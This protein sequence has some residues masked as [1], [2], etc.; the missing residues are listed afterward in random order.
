MAAWHWL[1]ADYGTATEILSSEWFRLA[2]AKVR[3]VSYNGV[4][5]TS[6]SPVGLLP[7]VLFLFRMGHPNGL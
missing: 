1:A 2:G 6:A 3:V 4:V 5:Q 7:T